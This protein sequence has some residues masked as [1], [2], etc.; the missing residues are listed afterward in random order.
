MTAFLSRAAAPLF[1]VIWATGFIAARLVVPHA[2]PFTFLSLR[3]ALVLAV[4]APAALLAGAEWPSRWEGWRDGFVAGLLL[5][6]GYLGGVFWAV[7]NGLPAG[8]S[9]L[10]AGLQPLFVASLAGALLDE[11]VSAQRWL[12]ILVGFGGAV[13]V[14]LPR[15]GEA[16]TG[17]GLIVVG[18]SLLSTL[19]QTA[20]TLWQKRKAAG[21]DLRS[22]AVLQYCGA[23]LGTLPAALI[24]ESGR[25]DPVP[26]F[27][28]GLSWSVL[29]LS[30]G[31]V[32]LFL[33]L[34]R[35]GAV[36]GVSALM[37][38]VPPVAA[39]MSFVLFGETLSAVQIVGMLV[40]AIGVALASRG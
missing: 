3:Y 14:I 16:G 39:V 40:A 21:V 34:L 11:R 33:M 23:A 37:Y 12:G 27:W 18:V 32:G 24:L 9:A 29:V 26:E 10:I 5:H 15:L 7:A 22:N 31:G 30:I 20:G 8:I 25:V 2:E 36:A 4:L 38:L 28:L 17:I 13:L 35:R 19:S 6:G 1:V